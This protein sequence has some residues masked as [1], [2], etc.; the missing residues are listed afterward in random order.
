MKAELKHEIYHK[1]SE[2]KWIHYTAT[3]KDGCLSFYEDGVLTSTHDKVS[4]A[5]NPVIKI[6]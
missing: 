1:N 3:L 5:G 4:K 6:K 2:G